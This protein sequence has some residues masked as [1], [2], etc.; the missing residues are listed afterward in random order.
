RRNSTI[1]RKA[2]ED[3]RRLVPAILRAISANCAMAFGGRVDGRW[4]GPI[5]PTRPPP[6]GPRVVLGRSVD[7]CSVGGRDADRCRACRRGGARGALGVTGRFPAGRLGFLSGPGAGGPPDRS[8]ADRGF[9]T[10]TVKRAGPPGSAAA[11]AG[12]SAIWG[13]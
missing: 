2:S 3:P 4:R 11:L 7:R 12:R 8:G 1:R 5:R 13:F 6:A 9:T 10:P